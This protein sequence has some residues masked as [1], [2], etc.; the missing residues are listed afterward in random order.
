M[1]RDDDGGP[2]GSTAFGR[3]KGGCRTMSTIGFGL[4]ARIKAG[5]TFDI[6]RRQVAP[7]VWQITETH[8]H[9]ERACAVLQDDRDSR[10]TR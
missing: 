9:I 3:S 2:G 8:V 1:S 10:R 6:E 7:G 5:S 4:L